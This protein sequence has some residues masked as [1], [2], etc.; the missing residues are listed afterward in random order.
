MA[1]L[2]ETLAVVG[3]RK[4]DGSANATGKAFFYQPGSSSLATVW[5]NADET[6]TASNPLTLNGA[7]QG[8]VYFTDA[9][10]V[11]FETSAGLTVGNTLKLSERAER[12]YV[13]NDGF[14]GT[15]A[16]GSLG[17]GGETD[18]DT[19]LSSIA[20]SVGGLDGK[21]KEF[22][23]ATARKL[24]EVIRGIQVSVKDYGAVGNN[25]AD[26]VVAIQA[27]INEVGR[28]GGGGVWLDPGTYAIS[29]ALTNTSKNGV[30]IIGSGP[31]ASVI[32][33]TSTTANIFTLASCSG[34]LIR[35]LGL[36]S[37]ATNSGTAIA[38]TGCSS[39]VV[40]TVTIDGSGGGKFLV[41]ASVGGAASKTTFSNCIMSAKAADATARG[42]TY[43]A[44][45]GAGHTVLN[46]NIDAGSGQ[47][48]AFDLATGQVVLVG[49]SLSGATTFAATLTGNG[50][51]I[52][53]NHFA[54]G[55]VVSATAELILFQSG[56]RWAAHTASFAV[57]TTQTPQVMSGL[58]HLTASSGG[59]GA[60]AVNVPSP[61]AAT[62]RSVFYIMFTN[63]SGGAVTWNL[64]AGYRLVGGAAPAATDGHTVTLAFQFDLEAGLYRELSGRTDTLT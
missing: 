30:S 64:A 40:D 54:S 35:N 55:V 2:F 12:V 58:S 14:T 24:L 31:T 41:C 33:S 51:N 20:A 53:G 61:A 6:A 32:R 56:N 1:S 62:A 34:F 29:S 50:Y 59:A 4:S 46:S 48:L 57:G 38:L 43:S 5:A 9:V 28:L 16:S 45:S 10:D 44:T 21:Y 25:V 23:G 27:A 22:T 15:L 52:V 8:T 42:I 60:V 49:N 39:F 37:T 3:H 13:K 26:D 36:T 11:R 47:S 18:L 19:V 7:G 17:A 63:A